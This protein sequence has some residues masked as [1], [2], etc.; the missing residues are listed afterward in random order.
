MA[1]D[2]KGQEGP[3]K[4]IIWAAVFYS[5]LVL[6]TAFAFIYI[7]HLVKG[8]SAAPVAIDQA[9]QAFQLMARLWITNPYTDRT[10]SLDYTDDLTRLNET[11]T[12]KKMAYKMTID[13]KETYYDKPYFE[14]AKQIGTVRYAGYKE[15]RNVD[16]KGTTKQL[17][18]EIQHPKKYARKT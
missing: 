2:K 15:K 9:T 14:L 17:E 7:P 1:W 3:E 16:V 12:T 5:V 13:G 18:I 8:A 6:G 11:D 10:S 4:I